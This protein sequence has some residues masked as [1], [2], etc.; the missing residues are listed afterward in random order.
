MNFLVIKH[1]LYMIRFV[2]YDSVF[3]T[4]ISQHSE[5]NMETTQEGQRPTQ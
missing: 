2:S 4:T 5:K 3:K 1:I